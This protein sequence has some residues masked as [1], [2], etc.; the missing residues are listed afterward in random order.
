ML[1]PGA[2]INNLLKAYANEWIY[3]H[4]DFEHIAFELGKLSP[5]SKTDA[6]IAKIEAAFVKLNDDGIRGFYERALARRQKPQAKPHDQGEHPAQ[7]SSPASSAGN[8]GTSQAHSAVIKDNYSLSPF[9]LLRQGY[10]KMA[11]Q[12]FRINLRHLR[13]NSPRGSP[14]SFIK[15]VFR[16]FFT[17]AAEIK[18]GRIFWKGSHTSLTPSMHKLAR[19]VAWRQ[20]S[21]SSS[22]VADRPQAAVMKQNQPDSFC[23][24]GR[25]R[26]AGGYRIIDRASSP[27]GQDLTMVG[28]RRPVLTRQALENPDTHKRQITDSPYGGY[29]FEPRKVRGIQPQRYKFLFW[30]DKFQLDWG[31]LIQKISRV[32]GVPKL[33]FFFKGSELGNSVFHG[34]SSP[35]IKVSFWFRHRAGGDYPRL[36]LAKISEY[37]SQVASALRLSQGQVSVV[38]G[39]EDIRVAIKARLFYLFGFHPVPC[40]VQD[41]RIVPDYFFYPQFSTS[42]RRIYRDTKDVKKNFIFMAGRDTRQ[43]L[44]FSPVSPAAVLPHAQVRAIW[45]HGPPL[46]QADVFLSHLLLTFAS[47]DSDYSISSIYIGL[48]ISIGGILLISSVAQGRVLDWSSAPISNLALIEAKLQS[49]VGLTWLDLSGYRLIEAR[50]Q[51]NGLDWSSASITVNDASAAGGCAS[52]ASSPASMA[53][54]VSLFDSSNP[55]GMVERAKG[56]N[57]VWQVLW[58]YFLKTESICFQASIGGS[59]AVG[60]VIANEMNDFI[61]ENP[62]ANPWNRDLYPKLSFVLYVEKRYR[63]K[64]IGSELLRVLMDFAKSNG[65]KILGYVRLCGEEGELLSKFLEGAYGFTIAKLPGDDI[66]GAGSVA[67]KEMIGYGEDAGTIASEAIASS[68]AGAGSKDSPN[69][70]KEGKDVVS[71]AWRRFMDQGNPYIRKACREYEDE[72]SETNAVGLLLPKA[73]HLSRMKEEILRLEAENIPEGCV[74]QESE[75]IIKRHAVKLH[76]GRAQIFQIVHH[77]TSYVEVTLEWL[78]H[79]PERV[80]I[81]DAVLKDF[82]RAVRELYVFLR[83]CEL[84]SQ[85]SSVTL[86]ERRQLVETLWAE[87]KRDFGIEA[88]SIFPDGKTGGVSSPAASA[89]LGEIEKQSHYGFL[90]M[91]RMSADVMSYLRRRGEIMALAGEAEIGRRSAEGIWDWNYGL[92][93]ER[94]AVILKNEFRYLP[95]EIEWFFRHIGIQRAF[96]D[97]SLARKAQAQVFEEERQEAL[98]R[99]ELP[100]PI[101]LEGGGKECLG[102]FVRAYHEWIETID[103]V[104]EYVWCRERE[105]KM[106]HID[107]C[108]WFISHDLGNA[109]QGVI[110]GS[111]NTKRR[112]IDSEVDYCLSHWQKIIKGEFLEGRQVLL[113]YEGIK[114]NPVPYQALVAYFP[115]YVFSR[116]PD[117]YW[118]VREYI[119]QFSKAW[120][121]LKKKLVAEEEKQTGDQAEG[122]GRK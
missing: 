88:D 61:E 86:R 100:E 40:Y 83:A 95:H 54:K 82:L 72:F 2:N 23:F 79:S 15:C 32:V 63:S 22:P 30:S 31:K 108:T 77:L 71:D 4:D 47:T 107:F 60:V 85:Y 45:S 121:E 26:G 64:G 69:T 24:I 35:F 118:L 96:A 106:W 62:I 78:S 46:H 117:A 21:A 87:N 52:G 89:G 98:S 74:R 114:E 67:W 7:T 28:M 10:F 50:L 68:P 70:D 84:Y 101:V 27:A 39:F 105:S 99:F 44:S 19:D 6:Y 14:L 34:L 9:N 103:R 3:A 94:V 66:V 65:H 51:S 113:Q 42:S 76:S 59:E 25:L 55:P 43:G 33:S 29:F 13:D 37:Y 49:A 57:G 120:E 116:N 91:Q 53:I 17:I 36:I 1:K 12:L 102:I 115:N 109:L 122:G 16:A 41:G 110:S 11:Y 80:A 112:C 58:P 5:G 93:D 119:L 8:D 111:E 18:N 75:A 73:R 56:Q 97:E 48:L 81:R 92:S 38:F 104:D 90:K 20:Q